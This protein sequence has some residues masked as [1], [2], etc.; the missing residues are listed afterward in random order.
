MKT[1]LILLAGFLLLA[2]APAWS[3]VTWSVTLNSDCTAV[4][5]PADCCV[6][7]GNGFCTPE[8]NSLGTRFIEF[9][10]LVATGTSTYTTGGDN[11]PALSL[12]RIGMTGAI[13]F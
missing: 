7:A 6:T 10:S 9:V 11:L 5:A 2:A 3:A 1:L 4:D 12:S 8:K 13:T